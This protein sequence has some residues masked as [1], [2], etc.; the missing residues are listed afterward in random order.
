M[1]LFSRMFGGKSDFSEDEL[2]A[3]ADALLDDVDKTMPHDLKAAMKKLL[4]RPKELERCFDF[5]GSH[6]ERFANLVL[7]AIFQ[8]H[9]KQANKVDKL[10]LSNLPSL[11]FF[12]DEDSEEMGRVIDATANVREDLML[13]RMTGKCKGYVDS[14]LTIEAMREFMVQPGLLLIFISDDYFLMERQLFYN[15]I[16]DLERDVAIT[17]LPEIVAE[18]VGAM[19]G[20]TEAER[21]VTAFGFEVFK[22][23]QQQD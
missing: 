4:K 19:E 9:R 20:V 10:T 12:S 22:Y 18:K 13:I 14:L 15:L 5:Y 6:R 21:A 23:Y 3:R 2:K 1:G 11:M 16:F 7:E 8:M 17:R